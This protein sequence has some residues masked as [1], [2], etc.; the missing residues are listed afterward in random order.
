MTA[1]ILNIFDVDGTLFRSPHP[2]RE[3][4]SKE[5]WGK[6]MARWYS[7]VATLSPPAI[8][9][10]LDDTMYYM[11][12]VRAL[13][14]SLD[15]PNTKTVVMTGRREDKGFRPC[16]ET[17]L[18]GTGIPDILE[19]LGG[20]LH[21]KPKKMPTEDFKKSYMSEYIRVVKPK[22]IEVWED[23]PGHVKAFKRFL[24]LGSKI[25]KFGYIVNQCHPVD[26]HVSPILER[27]IVTQW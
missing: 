11:D 25:S 15:A 26:H 21:L 2:N 6:V 9:F 18:K 7:D 10:E 20:D 19:R 16:I 24:E 14:Q 13:K 4:W 8:P 23:R 5:Q 1:N 12:V 22:F 17:I 27:Q 3:L